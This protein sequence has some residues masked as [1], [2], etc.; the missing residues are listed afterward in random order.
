M[1]INEIRK[2]YV[3]NLADKVWK[4]YAGSK[5]PVFLNDIVKQLRITVK[6]LNLD[7]NGLTIMDNNGFYAISY[8]G[9]ISRNRQKF[10]VAHE[11][12]HIFLEHITF[13]KNTSTLSNKIKEDE[14]D[15]FAG[16]LLVPPLDLKKYCTG[17]KISLD[18]L[19]KR[20]DV[21]KSVITISVIENKLLN[22]ICK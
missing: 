4:E 18:D 8:S 7:I 11:I 5:V 1:A 22:N 21:S 15:L 20:Y 13:S 17:R 2:K 6:C 10:T 12:G 9:S 3:M 19:R 16:T 14:A